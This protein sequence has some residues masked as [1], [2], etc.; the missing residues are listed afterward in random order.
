[1]TPNL[2]R[3]AAQ[4]NFVLAL[5]FDNGES[6]VLDMK[7][8]LDFGVFRKLQSPAFFSQVRVS[9]DTLEWPTGIDLAP[10]FIYNKSTTAIRKQQ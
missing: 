9:F 7:P 1:M 4:E 2:T 5:E 6:R 8:Y 10:D 3:V